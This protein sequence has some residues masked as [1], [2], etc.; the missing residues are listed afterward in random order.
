MREIVE[1][2]IVETRAMK[3]QLTIYSLKA[4]VI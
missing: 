4:P 2:K 1:K 3:P